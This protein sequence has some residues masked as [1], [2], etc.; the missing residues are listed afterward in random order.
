MPAHL[1]KEAPLEEHLIVEEDARHSL[2]VGRDV[3]LAHA[4]VRLHGV[5]ALRSKILLVIRTTLKAFATC[6][7]SAPYVTNILSKC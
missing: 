4:E 1:I 3:K 5:S 6:K 7:A 2:P